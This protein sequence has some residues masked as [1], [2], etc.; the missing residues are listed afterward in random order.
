MGTKLSIS[1]ESFSKHLIDIHEIHPSSLA[2][3]KYEPS[4]SLY[5]LVCPLAVKILVGSLYNQYINSQ[6]HNQILV[7]TKSKQRYAFYCPVSTIRI[8]TAGFLENCWQSNM[9]ANFLEKNMDIG[10]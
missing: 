2:I 6:V 9:D 8:Y 7:S 10:Y 3:L 1:L 5:R 4:R